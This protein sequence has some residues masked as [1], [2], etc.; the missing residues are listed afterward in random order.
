MTATCL[1]IIG[2]EGPACIEGPFATNRH[3]AEMLAAVLPGGVIAVTG[4][5]TGTSTGAAL[6]ALPPPAAPPGGERAD[7]RVRPGLAE[8]AAA[9]RAR[10]GHG[11]R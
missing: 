10:S 11:R 6:L 3:F 8:Y 7:A 5:S 4:A 9:W 2:A 1:E